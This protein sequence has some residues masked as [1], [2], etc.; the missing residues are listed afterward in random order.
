MA[1]IRKRGPNYYL[2]HNVRQQGRIRQIHLA[3]LGQR[4]R[5]SD[6]VV[7]GVTSKHPFLQVDW[8]QL[9]QKTSRDL[10][11]PFEQ[12]SR[13]LRDLL[14]EIRNLHFD[15][16]DLPLPLLDLT[17]DR[18]LSAELISGLRLLRT[19]LDVKLNKLRKVKS[20]SFNT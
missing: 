12:D 15:L 11:Q 5:I 8:K 17:K 20:L 10:I 2:V 6:D 18:E 3:C 1:F 9:R 16:A 4:P 7:R 14:L 19:T 13:Y